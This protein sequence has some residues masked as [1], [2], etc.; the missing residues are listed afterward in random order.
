[1]NPYHPFL[2][3][4]KCYLRGLEETD[5]EGNYFQW[6]NDQEVTAFMRNGTFPNSAAKARDFFLRMSSSENDI[7]LAI[8]GKDDG[9]HVGNLGL[10]GINWLYR[11][12]ELGIIVGERDCH[13][14]GLATEAMRLLLGHAFNRLNL[15]RVYL[16]TDIEN[17]AAIRAFEKAGFV[18][19]GVLRQDCF[20]LGRYRDSIYMG[21]L[22][23]DYERAKTGLSCE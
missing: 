9:R 18:R 19:E 17:K 13:G 11:S 23:E 10:H 21:C 8:I 4:E 3:G 12:A 1:M 15:H 6:F 2:I 5:L 20:R 16:I 22:A 14:K 7:V